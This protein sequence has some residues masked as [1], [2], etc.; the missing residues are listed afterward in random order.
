MGI[1]ALELIEKLPPKQAIAIKLKHLEKMTLEQIARHQNTEPKT[2]K[3]RIHSGM[4]KLRNEFLKG[5][6]GNVGK[7][8]SA[9]LRSFHCTACGTHLCRS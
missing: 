5:G 8:I 2:I 7:T 6:G 3:S 1:K 4:T 9:H